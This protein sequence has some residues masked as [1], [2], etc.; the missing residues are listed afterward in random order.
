MLCPSASQTAAAFQR[1]NYYVRVCIGLI[2]AMQI[3]STVGGCA[4]GKQEQQQTNLR[5]LAALY[6]QYRA[7]HRGS[8]PPNENDFKNSIITKSGNALKE[9]GTTIDELFTSN[10]D[11]KPFAVKYG[12]TKSWGL[13]DVIIY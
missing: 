13:P 7:E 4:R 3:C 1:I 10:R 5:S 2:V 12:S 11:G 9:R 6:S 8:P